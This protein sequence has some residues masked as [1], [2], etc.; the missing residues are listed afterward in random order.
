MK[1]TSETLAL[2][3]GKLLLA[4]QLKVTT[5]ESCTGG[6]VA[7]AITGI[8]G[9]SDW[10]EMG[11]V[12][13]SNSAKQKLVGVSPASLMA[14]GAVSEAVVREMA[15]GALAVSGANLAV[16]ISGIAGPNGGTDEKPVGTVW[17]AWATDFSP[18]VVVE[19]HLFHGGRAEVRSQAVMAGLRG[20]IELLN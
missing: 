13:Y 2:Q 10:F 14:H 12:T 4:K 18:E 5:V 6:G 11:L 1:T 9:S 15:E 20:L 19:H 7:T 3:L 8:S 17:F 16:A